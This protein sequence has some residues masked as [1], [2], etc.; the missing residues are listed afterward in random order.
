MLRDHTLKVH[1]ENSVTVRKQYIFFF[2]VGQK[3]HIGVKNFNAVRKIPAARSKG[4][5]NEQT[6]A[7]SG[8]IPR[9]SGSQVI[10]QGLIIPFG[11]YP[12]PVDSGVHHTAQRKIDHAVSA[13]DGYAGHSAPVRQFPNRFLMHIGEKQ[14]HHIISAHLSPPPEYLCQSSPWGAPRRRRRF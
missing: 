6:V 4:R 3:A 11:N 8:K 13:A 14:P 5:Q 12:Y 10:H 7:F 1:I 9:L 2:A